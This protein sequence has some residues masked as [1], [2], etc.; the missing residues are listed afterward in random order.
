MNLVNLI[1]SPMVKKVD[2]NC[3]GVDLVEY[4]G[5]FCYK[6]HSVDNSTASAIKFVK[7]LIKRGHYSVFEHLIFC[8]SISDGYKNKI[9]RCMGHGTNGYNDLKYFNMTVGNGRILIS[10]S[11]RAFNES[12]NPYIKNMLHLVDPVYVYTTLSENANLL[13]EVET[14]VQIFDVSSCSNLSKEEVANHVYM[15]MQIAC[16]RGITHELVRHRNCAFTQEST[17]YCNYTQERFGGITYVRPPEEFFPKGTDDWE[18]CKALMNACSDMYTKLVGKGVPPQSA[19]SILPMALKSEI[20]MTAPM[21]EWSHFL[22]L[23]YHE[24]TGKA[25]P[26]MKQVAK[27]IKDFY[28]KE[29]LSYFKF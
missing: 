5:R 8:F 24:V 28:D 18:E 26:Q 20:I 27:Q 9:I 11:M 19:R 1:T 21:Q 10:G 4:I 16:D 6:S 3:I 2:R 14:Y 29:V 25:H 15:T 22:N 7:G 13:N 17:R 12:N 23:R